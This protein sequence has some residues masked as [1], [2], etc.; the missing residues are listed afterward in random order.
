MTHEW[1]GDGNYCKK[2]SLNIVCLDCGEGV[3]T[4]H[5]PPRAN[6]FLKCPKCDGFKF[7]IWR[8]NPDIGSWCENC[9][10]NCKA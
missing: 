5:L 10:E 8:G 6:E 9:E 2:G 4:H 7:W 3:W 1:D